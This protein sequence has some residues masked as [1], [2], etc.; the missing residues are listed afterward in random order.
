MTN[1]SLYSMVPVRAV[2]FEALRTRIETQ[3]RQCQAHK[4]KL[5]VSGVPENNRG[6]KIG[7]SGCH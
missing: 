4:I 5:E 7:C 6:W 2:G 1:A 3:D